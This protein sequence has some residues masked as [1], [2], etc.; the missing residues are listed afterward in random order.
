MKKKWLATQIDNGHV[1]L[2]SG[3]GTPGA[4][5]SFSDFRPAL[6]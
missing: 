4:K 6:I 1:C 3:E 5:P 2:K